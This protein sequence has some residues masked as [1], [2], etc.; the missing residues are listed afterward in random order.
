M[1]LGDPSLH[2]ACCRIRLTNEGVVGMCL[3]IVEQRESLGC[4]ER[5]IAHLGKQGC[6]TVYLPQGGCHHDQHGIYLVGEPLLIGCHAW[7]V[8]ISQ[9]VEIDMRQEPWWVLPRLEFQQADVPRFGIDEPRG[10]GGNITPDES[11]TIQVIE[12]PLDLGGASGQ[13]RLARQPSHRG[14]RSTTPGF[15]PR[16]G[17]A[18]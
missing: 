2:V 3:H 15:C 12:D 4:Q 10:I 8:R 16:C 9:Q 13:A 18:R 5:G 11:R 17:T 6:V 7:G 1:N 14:R